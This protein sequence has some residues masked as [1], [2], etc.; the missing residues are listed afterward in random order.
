MR[1]PTKFM[2]HFGVA[3]ATLL[4]A[5]VAFVGWVDPFRNLGFQWSI[6]FISDR[7]QAYKRFKVIE[8][9]KGITDLVIGS[10]TS[11]IFVPRVL[12]ER[13]GVTAF[14]S[15]S[16]GA[17]LPLRLILL[18]HA[19][20]TQP[21][22]KR[23]I[24]VSDL[25]EFSKP[26]LETTVYYQDEMMKWL[27]PRH[28][29][30]LKPEASERFNDFFSFMVLDRAFRT[31]KDYRASLAGKWSSAYHADGS[32]TQ[33]MIGGKSGDTLEN[34]VNASAIAMSPFYS[35]MNSL[36]PIARELFDEV[37][38][39]IKQRPGVE[40]HLVLSPFHELFYRHFES[41][42]LNTGVYEAWIHFLQSQE[43]ES[44]HVHNFSYPRYQDYG[45]TP[46]DRFWQDGTHTTSEVMIKMA[47]EIYGPSKKEQN[48]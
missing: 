41:H 32:T 19:L 36:D 12:M 33:S 9:A 8:E 37:I 18:R 2:M 28:W 39:E 40:L 24:Y 46:T 1:N 15:N 25:F 38:Q 34:R 11:E 20:A 6:D 35:E 22:I 29:A 5:G 23:V 4:L 44:I 31:F 43:R 14:A 26:K 16:G 21:S 47:D 10:S 7:N 3:T 45:I 48:P 17:S 42:L 30:S 13:Y 27:D